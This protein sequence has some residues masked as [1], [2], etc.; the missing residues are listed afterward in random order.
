MATGKQY[1]K[2]AVERCNIRPSIPYERE[3]CQDF[4]EE[5]A[6]ECGVTM[7]YKGSNHMARSMDWLMPIEDAWTF[8][9]LEEGCALFI[10]DPTKQPKGYNDGR[11]DYNHVGLYVGEDALIDRDKNGRE[12]SCNV[13]H[14]S[15]TQRRVAGSRLDKKLVSGG[16]SHA[17]GFKEI[18]YDGTAIADNS[19]GVVDVQPAAPESNA[20]AAVKE[21]IRVQTPD[22]NPVKI[23]EKH[24]TSIYKYKAPNG[25]VLLKTGSKDKYFKVLYEGKER[26]VHRDFVVPHEVG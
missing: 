3:D 2:K 13:V 9:M 19:D 23:R 17:G 1:A 4:L 18:R 25:T 6:R 12:R 10:H 7:D 8:G 5:T 11:G 14:S 20:P 22:G 16:W 21:Y 15:S 26:L 24:N